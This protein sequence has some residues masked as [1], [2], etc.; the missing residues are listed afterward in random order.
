ME[1]FF[2]RSDVTIV[3]FFATE[4]SKTFEAFG[5]AAEMVSPRVAL[6]RS[7]GVSEACFLFSSRFHSNL[8][9]KCILRF[10][11]T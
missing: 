5:D 10:S 1:R 7:C 2:E 3:G 9:T 11:V 6:K 4:D 8:K